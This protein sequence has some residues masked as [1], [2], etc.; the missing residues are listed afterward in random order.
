MRELR[1]LREKVIRQRL[2]RGVT[3]GDVP[4]G[5]E[6]DD[7]ASFYTSV[8]DGL[9]I[10]SRDGASRKTLLAIVEGAMAAWD[11]MTGTKARAGP[12]AV[13]PLG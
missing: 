10:R 6:V 2:L 9:S 3:D 12:R 7:L 8:V 5:S 13:A 1:S 11:S 4:A